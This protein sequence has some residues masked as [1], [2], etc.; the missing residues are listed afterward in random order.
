MVDQLARQKKEI[1]SISNDYS[2]LNRWKRW[3]LAKLMRP[4]SV[5]SVP[6]L[7]SLNR[8]QTGLGEESRN[9]KIL[10]ADIV[11]N[12]RDFSQNKERIDTLFKESYKQLK[13]EREQLQGQLAI[14][15]GDITSDIDKVKTKHEFKEF[16][17][18]LFISEIDFRLS[19]NIIYCLAD[20]LNNSLAL[21]LKSAVLT[22]D[23]QV[24]RPTIFIKL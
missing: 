17:N 16:C 18:R 4:P 20:E 23:D 6:M 9:V 1:E 7:E 11:K 24:R 5:R 19:A 15:E 8:A 21:I 12:A 13:V 3:D 2:I 14:N 10:C 22:D